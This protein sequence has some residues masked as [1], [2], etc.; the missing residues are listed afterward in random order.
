VI[1]YQSDKRQFLV[2]NDD[3]DIEDL[4]QVRYQ[5]IT[6]R[7]VG[8]S[9]LRSWRDSLGRMASVLRDEELP[10]DLGVAV[11]FHIPQSSKRIDVTLTGL[12]ADDAKHMVIVELKQ[13][14]TVQATM[15]D[16]I[17][18][19]FLGK[20]QREVVHPSYQAWSY[21]SL[22]EGFNT[23]VHEGDIDVHPCAYLH[24]YVRDGAIDAPQ[25][26]GYI[27]KAPL[28]LK[29]ETEKQ[30]LRDFIKARIRKG[31]RQQILYELESGKIRPSKALADSL[32]K[33]I[34][35]HPEFVL[36]DEQKTVFEAALAAGQTATSSHPK[37]LLVEGGPG[38]GKTVLAI[39]LLVALTAKG[40]VCAYVSKNAA[41]RRVY[42][43]KL[44][45]TMTR[46][47]YGNLFVSSGSFMKTPAD[48]YDVLIVDEAHRLN[49]KSGFYGNEGD[50][51]IKEIMA[52]AKCSVFF[53]D[54]DQRVTLRDIGTKQ[55]ISEFSKSRGAEL[56]EH[57]LASQFRCSGSDGYIAWLDNTLGI[58]DT[59]NTM[60]SRSEFDFQVFDT[61]S[62]LHSAIVS[63][64]ANN[65]ARVVAG[66]C[67]PW[68]SKKVAS[69]MDIKIGTYQKQWNLD[70]DGSLWI[71]AR[72]SVDQVGC[73]HTC[74]GLELDFVGVIIGPDF[75]VRNGLIRTV[76]EA[77]ARQD[78]SLKG[79]RT[80]LD[81]DPGKARRDADIIIKNTYRTLMSRGMKGC[82]VHC[83]DPETNAYFRQRISGAT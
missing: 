15:K 47:R 56:E 54:E 38:T 61:P 19:T 27:G 14:E 46:T 30:R 64:N 1:V 31:D 2:D 42:E 21:A 68:A 45:G 78:Q 63:K 25:Y 23:A 66:Y 60:L 70:T 32:V 51:Q 29:G 22:L 33:M 7:S 8:P 49:E 79:Y 4:I 52:S 50:H 44:T 40:L 65:K 41:P 11:E 39:N 48:S 75:V 16:G 18:V 82:Y 69:A 67:W 26:A 59:A 34:K 35:G 36:I 12:D 80:L 71:I 43:A 10:D 13:W 53:I 55:A 9:E 20:G 6:G 28:F 58:R 37:V 57:V 5:S 83:T 24:N 77:R 3:R 73:I 17:V 76:P 74:Q 72:H 81:A 62:A